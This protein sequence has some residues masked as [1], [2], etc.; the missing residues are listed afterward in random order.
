MLSNDNG[1]DNKNILF[2]I[3]KMLMIIYIFMNLD[4]SN[5]LSSIRMLL[6]KNFHSTFF[7]INRI[8]INSQWGKKYKNNLLDLIKKIKQTISVDINILII[9]IF[10]L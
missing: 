2:I 4:I 10:K 9:F 1:K 8:R 7:D 5:S 6:I 3:K